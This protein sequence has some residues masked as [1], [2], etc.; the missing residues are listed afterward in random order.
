MMIVFLMA[1]F[2]LVFAAVLFIFAGSWIKTDSSNALAGISLGLTFLLAAVLL[3]S[4]SVKDEN[5]GY[6]ARNNHLEKNSVYEV[7]YAVE[8]GVS[9]DVLIRLPD[10][11]TVR[12]FKPDEEFQPGTYKAFNKLTAPGVHELS[13]KPFSSVPVEMA[14]EKE[15]EKEE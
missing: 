13:L 10:E 15:V 12:L 1:L 9:Y 5:I 8:D 7:L 4:S 14:V 11:R 6:A 3:I 2:S